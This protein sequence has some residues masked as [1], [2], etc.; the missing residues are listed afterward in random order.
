VTTLPL[1]IL[2]TTNGNP[3]N[4]WAMSAFIDWNEDGDFDDAGESYFN[5]TAT[6]IRVA[7]VATN[8]VPLTGNITIP[9][10]TTYGAKRMRV[11][12]NFSGTSIHTALMS[13]CAQM[14]NGQAEDYTLN[15]QEFLAVGDAAKTTVSVY[16]NPFTDVLRISDIKGIKSIN[17]VD[18]SG[19]TVR[20]MAPAAELNLS[21]LKSG[22]YM[23]TL[24]YEDGTVKTVKSIKK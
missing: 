14:G 23:V 1:T 3:V 11:K 9:A 10:G 13:G 16:P 24:R 8:P 22:L 21:N 12:Y 6:M 15:Y 20:T 7:G 17:I 4:G 2:G 5:T 19:R 18:A